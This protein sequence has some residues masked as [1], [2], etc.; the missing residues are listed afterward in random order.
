MESQLIYFD[1]EDESRDG[2]GWN[3]CDN[4]DGAVAL[5]FTSSRDAVEWCRRN[6]APFTMVR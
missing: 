4:Y 1:A 3:V 5:R 6:G 2:H